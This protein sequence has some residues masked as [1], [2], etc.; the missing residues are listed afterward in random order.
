[1]AN[2][3]L[4]DAQSLWAKSNVLAEFMLEKHFPLLN[5]QPNGHN[6]LKKIKFE[7]FVSIKKKKYFTCIDLLYKL[8]PV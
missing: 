7:Y 4:L 3:E 1:M 8:N 5:V 6:E 2:V